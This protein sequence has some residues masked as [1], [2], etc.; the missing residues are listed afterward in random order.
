MTH[1][2]REQL[3]LLLA[4]ALP[5]ENR[6]QVEGH[7]NGCDEC[8]DR[9]VLVMDG[10]AVGFRHELA[11]L[12]VE[13]SLPQAQRAGAHAFQPRRH[14]IGCGRRLRRGRWLGRSRLRFCCDRRFGSG[15]FNGG[16][17][18]GCCGQAGHEPY[19]S[20]GQ[21]GERVNRWI[22][23]PIVVIVSVDQHRLASRPPIQPRAR[24]RPR[25]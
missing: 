18:A 8:L 23:R 3:H 22:E 21:C 9:G 20:S 14:G 10:D 13:R 15:R 16:R 5:P 6:D 1:P 25:S 7:V 12:A 2:S 24:L 17:S 4:E 11:R 19:P